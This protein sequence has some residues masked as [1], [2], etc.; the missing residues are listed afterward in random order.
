[1]F[2][3]AADM[4]SPNAA[5]SPA[6]DN[7]WIAHRQ[8]TMYRLQAWPWTICRSRMQPEMQPRANCLSLVER[9]SHAADDLNSI[10]ALGC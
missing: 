4:K 10:G 8:Q 2:R 9:M 7:A 6:G 1:M 5:R 3:P